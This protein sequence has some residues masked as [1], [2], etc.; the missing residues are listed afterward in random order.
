M[1]KPQRNL[2]QWAA[3]IRLALCQ[4]CNRPLVKCPNHDARTCT[5]CGTFVPEGVRLE[6]LARIRMGRSFGYPL[7]QWP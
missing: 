5:S 1:K 2:R 7:G 3:R 6:W 4:Y